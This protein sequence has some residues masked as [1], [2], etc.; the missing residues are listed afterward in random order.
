MRAVFSAE[1]SA[2]ARTVLVAGRGLA[3]VVT[4]SRRAQLAI[5]VGP[6]AGRS[7]AQAADACGS[8]T[9]LCGSAR[10]EHRPAGVSR[11]ARCGA[12]PRCAPRSRVRAGGRAAAPRSDPAGEHH[13]RRGSARRSAR[14]FGPGAVAPGRRRGR[15]ACRA[16]RHG[17]ARVDVCARCLLARR[18]PPRVRQARQSHAYPRGTGRSWRG[19]GHSRVG[20]ARAAG[21]ARAG[22]RPARRQGAARRV[23]AV[24][25]SSGGPRCDASRGD[26]HP[27]D[28]DLHDSSRSQPD[29]PVRL[30]RRV[31]RPIGPASAADGAD[32]SGISGRLPPVRRAGGRSERRSNGCWECRRSNE[33]CRI[34]HSR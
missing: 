20:V 28:G 14:P 30:F 27:A 12:R 29:R 15:I 17:P 10:G 11:T 24:L 34:E 5:V 18:N 31:R 1:A 25:G 32:G 21:P 4:R 9:A 6:A 2:S 7:G 19:T 23:S 22:R 8:R 33:E 13:G 3:A 16:D 26:A